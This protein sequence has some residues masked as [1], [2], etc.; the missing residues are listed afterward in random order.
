M[1]EAGPACRPRLRGTFGSGALCEHPASSDSD[2]HCEMTFAFSRLHS[3][4]EQGMT[5]LLSNYRLAVGKDLTNIWLVPPQEIPEMLGKSEMELRLTD[6]GRK[7]PFQRP[8]WLVVGGG[9]GAG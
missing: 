5:L 4:L 9:A 6:S 2:C 1:A 7:S 3:N 8:P